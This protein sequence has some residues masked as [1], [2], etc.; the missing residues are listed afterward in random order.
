MEEVTEAIDRGEEVDAIYLDFAKAFDKVSHKRLLGKLKGYGIKGKIYDW[1]KDFLSNR[2]QR[3]VING[4]FSHW[5]HVKSGIPQSSVLGPILFLI[6]INDLPDVLNCCM[7]LFVD[8]A[9]LYM[10]ITNSHDEEIL[11]R[12]LDDSDIWAEI[13]DMDFNTRNVNT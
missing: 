12:N 9:K 13:W 7:K 10:P 4:K 11:Q 8:D 5:I 6:F 2:R 3:A 1:I